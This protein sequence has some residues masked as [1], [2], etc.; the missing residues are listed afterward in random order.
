MNKWDRK[1][2][3]WLDCKSRNGNKQKNKEKR[4]VRKYTP[5]VQTLASHER[6]RSRPPFVTL[7][8]PKIFS[9]VTAFGYVI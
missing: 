6:I 1:R 7:K 9:L 3:N 4:I 2:K 5:R 8:P